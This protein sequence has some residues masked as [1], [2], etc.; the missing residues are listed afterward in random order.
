TCFLFIFLLADHTGELIF[1]YLSQLNIVTVQG[2][3]SGLKAQQSQILIS[4]LLHNLLDDNDNGQ[5]SP[6][7]TAD[8]LFQQLG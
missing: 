8:F 4:T 1:S 5:L 7:P 6:N 2:K 3:L